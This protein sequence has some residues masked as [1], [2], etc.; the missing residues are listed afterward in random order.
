M[1]GLCGGKMFISTL[2]LVAVTMYSVS[3]QEI[4]ISVGERGS[5]KINCGE[6]LIN[7]CTA[8]YGRGSC[9]TC[10]GRVADLN[11]K[12][13]VVAVL[14][15][16]C[17]GRSQCT[18]N[19]TNKLVGDP[20][21]G[22]YKFLEVAYTCKGGQ[23]T[24]GECVGGNTNACKRFIPEIGCGKNLTAEEILEIL[25]NV[26]ITLDNAANVAEELE[27]VTR[28]GQNIFLEGLNVV[29]KLLEDI[30]EINSTETKV[31]ESM[32]GIVNNV[33]ALPDELLGMAEEEN[34]SPS[35]VILALEAQLAV[36]E[37]GNG[38]S[39]FVETNVAAEVGQT[40]IAH[41]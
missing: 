40:D 3:G 31:A 15:P 28:M 6:G 21:K 41:R 16:D 1:S 26:E 4:K 5:A 37:V 29:A 35:R 14:G 17:N 12:V 9:T 39:R 33:A 30:N 27:N 11:C 8:V 22:T 32:V 7:I 36:K 19:S 24:G 25:R 18:I 20:C 13:D 2:F 23:A 10:R 34:S 38:S